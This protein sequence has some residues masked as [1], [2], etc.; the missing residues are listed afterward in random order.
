MS[1][2]PRLLLLG[3]LEFVSADGQDGLQARRLALLAVLA[4]SG[5]AGIDRDELAG[6]FWPTVSTKKARHSLSSALSALRNRLGEDAIRTDK[7]VV[8]LRD[9][10]C[11]VDAIE[12]RGAYAAH[13]W[14]DATALYQGP[15]L[16]GF[17]TQ[18]L[19]E[20]ERWLL[21]RRIEFEQL[22]GSALKQ[23]A[24]S[25]DARGDHPTSVRTWRRLA[26]HNRF[27]AKIAAGL[28]RSLHASG[29]AQAAL[30]HASEYRSRMR[31][32]LGLEHDS[33]INALEAEIR[34]SLSPGGGARTETA[35]DRGARPT[36]AEANPAGAPSPFPRARPA[37]PHAR[38]PRGVWRSGLAVTAIAVVATVLTIA[39]PRPVA[40]PLVA[41]MAD[42][43]SD[44]VDTEIAS[45]VGEL[46]RVALA[47]S[48]HISVLGTDRVHSGLRLMRGDSDRGITPAV[49]RELALREGVG[50]VI[51]GEVHQAGSGLLLIARVVD[52]ESG[53][54][55]A[56]AAHR[57][58]VRDSTDLVS[59]VDRLSRAL[60]A[61]AGDAAEE[62]EGGAAL[63]R[64]TTAS[65][66][67]LRL[68][69]QAERYHTRSVDPE[70]AAALLESAVE[71][72][73]T[74]AT[75]HLRLAGLRRELGQRT[76][77]RQAIQ[78]A[79]ARRDRLPPI[80]QSTVEA[81]YALL[82]LGDRERAIAAYDLA[83][84]ERPDD[85]RLLFALGDA[86]Q[87]G[88]EWAAAAA[89]FAQALEVD[90]GFFPAREGLV[91]AQWQLGRRQAAVRTVRSFEG[92]SVA[93]PRQLL[94]ESR[95]AEAEGRLAEAEA[96]A[97]EALS[98]LPLGSSVLREM[99]L[100]RIGTLA[101]V[102]GRIRA[103]QRALEQSAEIAWTGGRRGAALTTVTI[104]AA[105]LWQLTRDSQRASFWLD[106]RLRLYAVDS[107]PR[108]DRPYLN[109]SVTY[110]LLGRVR[111]AKQALADHNATPAEQFLRFVR[112]PLETYARGVLHFA[113]GQHALASDAVERAALGMRCGSCTIPMRTLIVDASG[114]RSRS[115]SLIRT[116]LSTPRWN[117]GVIVNPVQGGAPFWTGPALE[118]L[119][120]SAY[121][122]GDREEAERHDRLL[123]ALWSAA[124]TE[125]LPRV[126]TA[127]ERLD[128]ITAGSVRP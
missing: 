93:D 71:L 89:H 98:L 19:P 66:P 70:V 94:L 75:A 44:Q 28:M 34:A 120:R 48:D 7:R 12:F 50:A 108:L 91:A 23:L 1:D 77:A 128:A 81:E 80:E 13:R 47:R 73:S 92:A 54:V 11:R 114:D 85:L 33:L 122:A 102:R 26:E 83:L 103:G 17:P 82:V 60:R 97:E 43:S 74:F 40:E 25:A 116:F 20:L 6:L 56:D 27:S 96:R 76:L 62:I 100:R 90:P 67:A 113:E 119:A 45:T 51:E 78:A 10:V 72:D 21:S 86:H 79:Y 64:V 69:T 49:A 123:V 57:E 110:A 46:L 58:S 53:T 118:A 16:D 31:S 42:F 59:G 30:D 32:E 15:L 4:L 24:A 88:R 115:V 84:A 14:E 63:E 5:R 117:D 8:A 95:L 87:W 111:E 52:P 106:E 39:L 109:L 125:L 55:L 35:G 37:R 18:E 36:G 127:Q 126:T 61:S 68:F 29:D 65:L 38:R 3:G 9:G 41:I 107:V 121:A 22:Y 112:G 101:L 2:R 99:T 124:D 104:G 105:G